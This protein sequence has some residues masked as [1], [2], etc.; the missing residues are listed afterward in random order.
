MDRVGSKATIGGVGE[1]DAKEAFERFWTGGG[2]EIDDLLPLDG[3]RRLDYRDALGL[4]RQEKSDQSDE[5]RD[6]ERK[7]LLRNQPAGDAGR[8]AGRPPRP[9]RNSRPR[10]PHRYQGILTPT[11]SSV[12]RSSIVRRC[13][14][15]RVTCAAASP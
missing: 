11:S 12:I 10:R 1:H 5:R 3:G 13:R 7:V 15:V 8:G 6:A 4:I 14:W 2:A 9:I